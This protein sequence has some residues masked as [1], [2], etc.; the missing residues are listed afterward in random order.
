M[1]QMSPTNS[2]ELVILD[3]PPHISYMNQ[4]EKRQLSTLWF[5]GMGP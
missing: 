4:R 1:S 2:A 5:F 3:F